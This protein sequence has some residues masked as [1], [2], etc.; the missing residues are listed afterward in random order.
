MIEL[1]FCKSDVHERLNGILSNKLAQPFEILKT[2]NGKPYLEGIPLHFSL[3]HS[4]DRGL[5][6]ISD[7][8]IGVDIEIFKDKLRKSVIERFSARE[9]S[10]IANERDFLIHWTAREAYVKLYGLTIAKMLNRVEFFGGKLYLNG[11]LQSVKIR[12]YYFS[13]GVAAVCT[14]E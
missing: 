7:K 4:A 10:E 14:E 2:E 8:P 3:S 6:T 5:I 1:Y 9:Q 12:H 11:Q 13:F